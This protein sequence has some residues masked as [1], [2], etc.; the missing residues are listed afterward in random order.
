MRGSHIHE[1]SLIGPTT[2]FLLPYC[3][4]QGSQVLLRYI[5]CDFLHQ[6]H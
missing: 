6:R 2:A 1:V 3:I 4:F 5:H